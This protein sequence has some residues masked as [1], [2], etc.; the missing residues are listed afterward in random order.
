MDLSEFE[1]RSMSWTYESLRFETQNWWHDW[2]FGCVQAKEDMNNMRSILSKR[3]SF[4]PD[5]TYW[6]ETLFFDFLVMI[7]FTF[8]VIDQ[9]T[10]MASKN[11]DDDA[12]TRL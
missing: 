9:W 3:E 4:E 1:N 8:S 7:F 5:L 2:S 11:D 12:S 10:S 6:P